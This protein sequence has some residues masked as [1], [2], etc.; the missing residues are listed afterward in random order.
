[1]RMRGFFP[2]FKS[3]KTEATSLAC[4][5]KEGGGD[6]GRIGEGGK[7]GSF[8]SLVASSDSGAE[9]IIVE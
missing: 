1:M 3:T 9:V 8:L 5:E 2:V 4:W 6:F 7:A